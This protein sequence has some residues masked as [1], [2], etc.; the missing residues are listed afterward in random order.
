MTLKLVIEL[1]EADL[2]YYRKVAQAIRRRNLQRGEKELVG[3]ARE[4][5]ERS[6]KAEAP[7]YVRKRL[8]DLGTLI[9]M[10]EDREWPLEQE[11]RQ[12]IVDAMRYFADPVDIIPDTLPGLGLL[13]DA[14][15]AE[16]VI[17]ELKHDLD[18]Y[19]DFRQYRENQ[20]ALRGKDV[21]VSREDWLAAKR[22]QIFLR[23]KR[24]QREHKRHGSRDAPTDPILSY[25]Y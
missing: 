3:R 1:G 11:D 17:R 20:E 19:R 4:L 6:R 18:G 16:L 15:M 12:R 23:I 9:A 14:L 8:D 25:R 13:D 22:R 7:D 10:L 21:R 5:L 24:R 2:E